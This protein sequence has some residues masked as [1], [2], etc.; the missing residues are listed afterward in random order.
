MIE[1]LVA[2]AIS[3]VLLAG[4]VQLFVANRKAFKLVDQLKLV[5][6]NSR[7]GMDLLARDVR[8]ASTGEGGR[9]IYIWDNDD[10][11]NDPAQTEGSIDRSALD[12]LPG[13][14]VLEVF[15]SQCSEPFII[16]DFN[17]NSASAPQLPMDLVASC[18]PCYNSGD[19]GGVL[20]A[21]AS[22]FNIR[23]NK[24]GSSYSCQH[25]ITSGNE[26]GGNRINLT[27]N[28]GQNID[29]ANRPHEC[30]DGIGGPPTWDAEAMI[31]IDVYYYVRA[32]DPDNPNSLTPI[33]QLMRYQVGLSPEVVA[34]YVEDF[35]ALAG[36]DSATPFDGTIDTWASGITDGTDVTAVKLSLMFKTPNIDPAKTGALPT[37]LENS[38]IAGIGTQ[39]KYRRRIITRVVRL[40]NMSN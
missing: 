31:G 11:N 27:W 19:G 3:T 1:M 25:N 30:N 32:D 36:E 37:Q 33:P 21:C 4:T 8:G 39:D 28:N 14:D 13:T 20:S 26:Q 24:I 12:V 5:E 34:N 10:A 16:T 2:M 40:R 6:E 9:P 7:I 38:G 23:L 35:Q 29:N 17:E 15:V 18:L 22:Q